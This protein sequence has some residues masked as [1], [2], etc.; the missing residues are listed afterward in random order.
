MKHSAGVAVVTVLDDRDVDVQ[1][2]AVLELPVAGDAVAD[3]LIDRGA[4][5]LGKAFVVQR[6][7]DRL[8]LVDDV[9]MA[10]AVQF[11]G[12]DA[13]LD[14]GRD[15]FQNFGGQAAGDAH[16]FNV[17]RGFEGDGH[18]GSLDVSGTRLVRKG[19]I[20]SDRPRR[21]IIASLLWAIDAS[22]KARQNK[23][24]MGVPFSSLL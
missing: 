17:F 18:T 12:G 23:N 13:R 16:L 15:H 6:S 7:R 24:L 9:V 8:L 14:M 5:R 4:D 22:L 21:V 10:D 3:H 11:F 2:V 1:R 19:A 20:L